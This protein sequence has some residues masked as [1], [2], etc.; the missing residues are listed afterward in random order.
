MIF[1]HVRLE[2]WGILCPEGS[3]VTAETTPYSFKYTQNAN[4]TQSKK[5]KKVK[6]QKM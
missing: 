4:D 6:W 3:S 1:E 2:R 5:S